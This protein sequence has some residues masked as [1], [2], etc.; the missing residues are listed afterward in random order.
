MDGLGNGLKIMIMLDL[1]RDE[2]D[3][4]LENEG[5]GKFDCLLFPF[6]FSHLADDEGLLA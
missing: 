6:C 4:M 5:S 2:D 1:V 3:A